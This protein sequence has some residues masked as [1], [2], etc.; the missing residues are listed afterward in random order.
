MKTNSYNYSKSHVVNLSKYS[1]VEF[2][3]FVK[4]PHVLMDLQGVF[5]FEKK[6]RLRSFLC[7]TSCMTGSKSRL[8]NDKI[9]VFFVFI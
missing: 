7:L 2:E 4:C 8:W 1:T 3:A 5:Y 6:T 9:N